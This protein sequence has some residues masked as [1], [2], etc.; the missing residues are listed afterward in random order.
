MPKDACYHSVKA[1]YEK[2][3]SARASQAIAKCRKKSGNTRRTSEGESLKRWAAEKW[4]EK[5]GEP[6]GTTGSYC[7]PTRRVSSETP[8]TRSQLSSSQEARAESAKKSG[9]RAP[10]YSKKK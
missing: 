6:C 10:T 5:S 2:F 4:E 1:R 9:R 8:R 7:R 3:P